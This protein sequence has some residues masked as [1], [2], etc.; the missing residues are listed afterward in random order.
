MTE[1]L[2]L[3]RLVGRIHD[4]ATLVA[5]A[6]SAELEIDIPEA[7]TLAQSE[8]AAGRYFG[9]GRHPY[10]DCFACG[11]ARAPGGGLAIL[12]GPL[13]GSDIV[14]APRIPGRCRRHR[15]TRIPVGGPRLPE[16]L[17]HAAGR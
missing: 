17:G 2:P 4:S 15:R 7:P 12:S 16:R 14:A 10:P 5:E 8:D 11:D 1:T 3:D 13:D 9:L 6:A